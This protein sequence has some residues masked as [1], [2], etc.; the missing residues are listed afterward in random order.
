MRDPRA[1]GEPQQLNPGA[2]GRL[3]GARGH[4]PAAAVL[5]EIGGDL[6][7]DEGDACDDILGEAAP[8]RGSSHGSPHFGDLAGVG[9]RTDH[10]HAKA[11]NA[12][13]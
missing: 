10:A 8:A 12:R 1:D 2:A 4:D 9:N 5:Q 6:G 7:G 3:Q 11:S 13:A